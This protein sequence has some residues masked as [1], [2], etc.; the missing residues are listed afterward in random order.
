LF[1]GREDELERPEE[2][3]WPDWSQPYRDA[4]EE[5]RDD[6]FYGA[7][8]GMSRIYSTSIDAYARRFGI[9]G[10]AF[11]HFSTFVRAIDD[12]YVAVQ[13]ERAEREAEKTKRS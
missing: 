2:A 4:F 6:R 9:D 10:T 13:L 12:E 7:M 5:L 11:E 8:G 1:E 3:C